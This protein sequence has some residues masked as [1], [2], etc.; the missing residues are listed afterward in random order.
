MKSKGIFSV[1]AV[2]TCVVL[3]GLGSAEPAY[4]HHS[5]TMFDKDV[6]ST[7]KGKVSKFRWTNPHVFVVVDMP[8]DT[9]E[10]VSYVLEGSSPNLLSHSGWNRKSI[11]TGDDV[12]IAYHPLRNGK[13]GG[14]LLTITLPDGTK[15]SAW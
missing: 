4:A 1:F 11:K 12:S 8:N 15:M 7:L 10:V 13:P 6:T 14:M 5:F 2:I 9:G 3:L